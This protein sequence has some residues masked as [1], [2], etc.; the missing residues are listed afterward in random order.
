MRVYVARHGETTWNVAGRYQGRRES[1]LTA[2]GE[3]QAMAL[4][5]ACVELEPRIERIISSPLRRCTATAGSVAERLGILVETDDRLIEIAHGTWEG[6][7]RADIAADDS[8][9]F[10][11]WKEQPA[12]VAFEGG[13]AL[14]DV[15]TRWRDFCST[16]DASLPTLIVTHDAV[17]RVAILDAQRR[18]LDDLW[19]VQVENAGF[20]EFA[21]NDG[22][23]TL[24]NENRND[25]LHGLHAAI[26]TQAL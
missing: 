10:G 4:A 3:R 23:W 5:D 21:V 9:L 13:E 7:L 16:I 1:Q 18:S 25:H 11:R 15:Q 20:A 8:E 2:L 26:Q 12:S 17:V 22:R 24:V 6:R 19:Q 14:A